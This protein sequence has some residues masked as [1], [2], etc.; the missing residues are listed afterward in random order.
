MVDKKI[1]LLILSLLFLGIVVSMTC[2]CIETNSQSTEVSTVFGGASIVKHEFLFGLMES[3]YDIQVSVLGADVV[4]IQ[5]IKES[6]LQQILA[7][8][9][10]KL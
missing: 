6:E 4:D 9:N 5:G 3:K 1:A 7:Q 10:I 2:G 8:Y